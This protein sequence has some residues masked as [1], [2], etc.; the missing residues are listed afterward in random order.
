MSS[1]DYQAK[2]D[3]YDEDKVFDTLY[4]DLEIAGTIFDN[5]KIYLLQGITVGAQNHAT[6]VI[7]AL[8]SKLSGML[9]NTDTQKSYT[10]THKSWSIFYAFKELLDL[11]QSSNAND[12]NEEYRLFYRGQ[13]GSWE[14]RPTIFRSGKSGYTD[15]FRNNY[16]QIYKSIARKFPERVKYVA[17]DNQDERA[18][19]LAELQHYGL[20]TPLI[21][22]TENP[23][24]AL[25]FM[26]EGYSSKVDKPEP[27]LDVYFC[28][29]DGQ[30]MLFQ[31]VKY[32]QNNPRIIAQK[33]A[34]LNFEKMDET[35]L[36]GKRKIPRVCIR[37]KYVEAELDDDDLR[38][39]P[40]GAAVEDSASIEGIREAALTTAVQDIQEKLESYF[41]KSED[42]FPDFY[43]YLN[44]LKQQYSST[45]VHR[46]WYRYTK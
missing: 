39:L 41:Y 9:N 6:K 16:E 23:F 18:A 36:S 7:K 8:E 22:I 45:D 15:Q 37:V 1:V 44:A 25:L 43:M 14:L 32:A 34:F 17:P 28:R 11:I 29:K 33:G 5:N 35:L 3:L 31:E 30:N 38:D 13:A 2:F 19:N 21:D 27:Q 40:D 20:G 26:V 46:P 10:G 12:L 24:I 4:L 42:L